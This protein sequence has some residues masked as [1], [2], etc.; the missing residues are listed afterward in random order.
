M[1]PVPE[2][3]LC[4]PQEAHRVFCVVTHQSTILLSPLYLLGMS[5]GDSS[6]APEDLR[7]KN[8]Q[9]LSPTYISASGMDM[10]R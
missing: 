2:I 7:G 5:I 1:D 4:C 3:A 6:K 8:G 10:G 9:G